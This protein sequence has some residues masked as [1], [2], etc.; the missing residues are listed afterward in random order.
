ME[1]Q[2]CSHKLIGLDALGLFFSLLFLK[3][4]D[5]KL[6]GDFF[7]NEE[8]EEGCVLVVEGLIFG[9]GGDVLEPALP[10]PARHR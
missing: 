9:C 6:L 5:G 8:G 7:E 4:V 1:L 3:A 10:Q 2:I